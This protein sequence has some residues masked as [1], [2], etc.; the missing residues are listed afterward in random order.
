MI[1]PEAVK[2]IIVEFNYPFEDGYS[3]L[4]EIYASK[5]QIEELYN[6]YM[7]KY[8]NEELQDTNFEEFLFDYDIEC[9]HISPDVILSF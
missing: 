8:N 9:N 6:S 5:Q 3:E 7:K 4:F 2:K 1:E